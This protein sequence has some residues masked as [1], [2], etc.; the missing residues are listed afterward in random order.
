MWFTLWVLG[1]GFDSKFMYIKII[2]DQEFIRR[3]YILIIR[4]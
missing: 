2:N 4:K 3:L 1:K